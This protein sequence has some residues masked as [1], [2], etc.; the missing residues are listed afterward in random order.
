MIGKS[1][2]EGLDI[3]CPTEYLFCSSRTNERVVNWFAC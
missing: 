1:F 3:G 2:N